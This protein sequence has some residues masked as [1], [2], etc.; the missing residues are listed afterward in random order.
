L[1]EKANSKGQVTTPV[2]RSGFSAPSARIAYNCSRVP[3]PD[4]NS[5]YFWSADADL[6]LRVSDLER[7]EMTVAFIDSNDWW[8][9]PDQWNSWNSWKSVAND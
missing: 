2:I 6:A 1:G 7:P 9:N 5:L 8:V 3:G 4:G